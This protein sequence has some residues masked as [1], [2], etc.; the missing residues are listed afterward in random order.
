MET[1]NEEEEEEI[2]EKLWELIV[3]KGKVEVE[4]KKIAEKPLLDNLSK[5]DYISFSK[6]KIKLTDKGHIVAKKVI[7][8]HR[9]AERLLY[10]VLQ[11]SKDRIEDPSCKFEHILTGEVEENIC[12]LLGHPKECPHGKPIP[13]GEC[14]ASNKQAI[15]KIV[16][17]L[18]ELKK[19]QSGKIAYILTQNHKKLQKLMALGVLPGKPIKVMQSFPS[20]VFQ[21]HNTQAV[22]DKELAKDIYIKIGK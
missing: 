11:I 12:I 3:E 20:Y 19:G 8:R 6:D 16:S 14:C 7:R 17:H 9:L 4:S 1:T 22:I 13:E 2:L 5:S 21:I 15:N 18:A 10:D